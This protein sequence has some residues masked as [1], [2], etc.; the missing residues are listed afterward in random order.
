MPKEAAADLK[1]AVEVEADKAGIG[2][3][4]EEGSGSN[5]QEYKSNDASVAGGI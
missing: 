5:R 3:P 1:R 2:S 4:L